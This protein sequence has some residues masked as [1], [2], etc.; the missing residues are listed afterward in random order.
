MAEQ[1]KMRTIAGIP[2]SLYRFTRTS[3]LRLLATR[4]ITG[5]DTMTQVQDWG[6]L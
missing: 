2:D 3:L 1:C 4:A 6:G 5:E